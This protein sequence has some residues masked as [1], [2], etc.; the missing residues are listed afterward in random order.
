MK[1]VKGKTAFITGGASGI[2]LGIAKIFAKAGVNVVIAD[3][4]EDHLDQAKKELNGARVHAVQ[5][6]VAD[7]KAFGAAADEAERV[8]GPVQ[9]VCNNAG[10]NMFAPMDECTYE[11]WDWIMGVNLGGVV[12][13]VQTFVPR[14][15]A[16]GKGG[17]IVN[18]GSMA[19]FIT[20]PG[21][22]IYTT[23]KF[24][25]RG[26]SESLRWSLAPYNIGVSVLCP[27]LVNSRIYESD[28]VRPK[29]LSKHIGPVDQAFMARLADVHKVGMDPVEVGE[30]VLAGIRRNDLFIFPHPE[31]RDELREIF[32]EVLAALPDG[33]ADPKRLAFEETRRMAKASVVT[34]AVAKSKAH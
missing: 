25:V 1:D 34:P 13:G 4:R 8:F 33:K 6:D 18:T 20:G 32:D 28:K 21:A 27:G 5:L 9:I 12:N 19:S 11:D 10:I 30:K 3:I 26:L 16:H 14:I 31:F 23:T 2:G 7:R 29:A 24:A 22:G 17:H 15:K